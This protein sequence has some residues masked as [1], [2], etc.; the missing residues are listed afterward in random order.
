MY[1]ISI[2]KVDRFK[3][4]F[5]ICYD[6]FFSYKRHEKMVQINHIDMQHNQRL[7]STS[8]LEEQ[9]DGETN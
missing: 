4:L 8:I 1:Q 6:D 7:L 2:K 5:Y 9:G 3:I